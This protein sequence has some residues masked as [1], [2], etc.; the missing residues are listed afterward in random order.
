[1]I[2][3]TVGTNEAPF[4]RLL[5]AID[6]LGLDEEL[7]VQCGSSE[8]RPQNARCLDFLS[9]E[10]V[11]DHVR[12]ARAVIAH[13]GVGT[14][15]TTLGIGKKPIVVPRLHRYRE[16]V[17]DHQVHFARRLHD[18]GLVQLVL[19]PTDLPDALAYEG[20]RELTDAGVRPES[21]LA[22]D[23]RAYLVVQL[24]AEATI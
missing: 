3:V 14:V 2:F 8:V 24:R 10:E 1:M 20:G 15:L 11:R 12:Q 6:V 9:F 21:G 13:A 23:L 16:A 19:D 17:D 5:R 22:E 18:E 7:V 4:D